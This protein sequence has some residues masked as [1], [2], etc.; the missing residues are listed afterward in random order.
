MGHGEELKSKYRKQLSFT[1]LGRK[2]FARL[3]QLKEKIENGC[4]N[5][6]NGSVNGQNGSAGDRNFSGKS[7][8]EVHYHSTRTSVSLPSSHKSP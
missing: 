2:W 6:E 7:A 4:V 1:A 5:C 8:K 3:Y